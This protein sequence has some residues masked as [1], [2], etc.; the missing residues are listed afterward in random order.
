MRYEDHAISQIANF[1]NSLSLLSSPRSRLSSKAFRHRQSIYHKHSSRHRELLDEDRSL[2]KL[3]KAK[4]I[5]KMLENNRH[6]NKLKR[7]I[8][9]ILEKNGE[10]CIS[11]SHVTYQEIERILGKRENV[12]EIE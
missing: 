3:Q 5:Q 4:C 2:R 6:S 12:V 8:V 7:E 9:D 10:S 1:H 11:M